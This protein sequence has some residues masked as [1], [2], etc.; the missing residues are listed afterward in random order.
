MAYQN[1]NTPHARYGPHPIDTHPYRQQPRSHSPS[2]ASDASYYSQIYPTSSPAMAHQD[3]NIP[4]GH[5]GPYPIDTTSYRQQP[6]SHSPSPASDASYYSQIYSNSSRQGSHSS[7]ALSDVSHDAFSTRYRS[8][9]V[10]DVSRYSQ[11]P[12]TTPPRARR[13]HSRSPSKYPNLDDVR[14]ITNKRRARARSTSQVGPIFPAEDLSQHMESMNVQKGGSCSPSPSA[15]SSSSHALPPPIDVPIVRPSSSAVGSSSSTADLGDIEIEDPD[16]ADLE[17]QY[18]PSDYE[19]E[20]PAADSTAP[21]PGLE[22]PAASLA[23]PAKQS[24]ESVAPN[25]KLTLAPESRKLEG[26]NYKYV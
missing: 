11:I 12:A 24:L 22:R 7:S 8:H 25:L 20:K 23:T 9:S 17:L 3:P 15:P 6:H 21:G 16:L 5:Y 19:E 10:S 18:P 26:V 4:Y 14:K 13:I 1:S 2:P